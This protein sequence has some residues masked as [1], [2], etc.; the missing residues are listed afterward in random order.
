MEKFDD[1]IEEQIV[2]PLSKSK[3]MLAFLGSLAFVATGIWIVVITEEIYITIAGSVGILFF[4]LCAVYCFFKFQDSAP[5]LIINHSCVIDNS[6]GIAAGEI[7]WSDV[8]EMAVLEIRG[9]KMVCMFVHNPEQYINR[10]KSFFRRFAMKQN[11]SMYGTPLIISSVS[12][13][14]SFDELLGVLNEYHMKSQA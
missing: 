8:I 10:Q 3:L 14:I 11:L 6:S 13:K 7:P 4:G 2:I 5:G 1:R 12:I 9:Q